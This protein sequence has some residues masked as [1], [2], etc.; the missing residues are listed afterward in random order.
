MMRKK[1]D[2]PLG[3]GQFNQAH[4]PAQAIYPCQACPL[5]ANLAFRRQTPDL[6]NYIEASKQRSVA[7][8]AGATIIAENQAQTHFFTLYQGWAFRYKSLPDD[9]RQILNFLLPGDLI[10]LQQQLGGQAAHGVAALTDVVLCEFSKTSLW[11]L[12]QTNP[13]LGYDITW[14]SA[15]EERMVDDNLLT[16]GRRSA[17]ER[18]A[19]LLLHLHDRLQA[20]QLQP[21][22]DMAFPLSQ[23]H[24]A[25]ALG[26]SLVHTNKTL[27]KLQ[28][29][30]LLEINTGRLRIRELKA[31][32]QLAHY[33][34]PKLNKR[35][36]L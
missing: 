26:L 34:S 2:S 13:E 18:I 7:M 23:Q 12:Y 21:E 22:D 29:R 27:R 8:Q 6:I 32:S 4:E 36:L 25:D 19:H 16:V 35:P 9:R 20:L 1:I 17:E 15:Y 14:L 10:G 3:V 24:I 28:Q 5:R 11:S 33:V 31:L 30:Q